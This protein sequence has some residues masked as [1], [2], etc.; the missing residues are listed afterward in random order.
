MADL[1][2]VFHWTPETLNRM[3]LRELAGWREKA[4]ARV[5][6]DAGSRP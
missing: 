3:S 2:L 5:A 4:R 6:P 1:A